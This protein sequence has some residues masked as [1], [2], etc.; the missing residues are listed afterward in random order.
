MLKINFEN[1][2]SGPRKIDNGEYILLDATNKRPINLSTHWDAC[3]MPGQRVEMRMIFQRQ[4]KQLNSCPSCNYTYGQHTDEDVECTNCGLTFKRVIQIEEPPTDPR[5]EPKKRGVRDL[6]ELSA[7]LSHAGKV[8][9]RLSPP[10]PPMTVYDETEDIKYYRRVNVVQRQRRAVWELGK[11]FDSRTDQQIHQ[12]QENEDKMVLDRIATEDSSDAGDIEILEIFGDS[13]DA[14][15]F[16]SFM[17]MDDDDEPEFS[18][19]I[20]IN[21]LEQIEYAIRKIQEAL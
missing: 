20:M 10:R 12:A 7:A 9:E 2:P 18:K 15:T 1:I 19:S 21:G 16:E 11:E 4:T 3:L 8:S 17:E 5:A 13:V 6:L 14:A